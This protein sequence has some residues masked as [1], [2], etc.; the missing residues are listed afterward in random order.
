MFSL[1]WWRHRKAG[2][3]YP[4][5]AP[6]FTLYFSGVRVTRSLFYM[7]VLLIVVCPFVHFLFGHYVVCSFSICGFWLPLGI[8]KLFFKNCVWS[9]VCILYLLNSKIL[10][11]H[12]I[13]YIFLYVFPKRIFYFH[14]LLVHILRKECSGCKMMWYSLS[15]TFGRVLRFPPPL[16]LTATIELK[17]CWNWH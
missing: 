13:F 12:A 10:F 14:V 4:S 16:K 5:G 7:Y 3:V 9:I 11:K 8:F 1:L 17:Y 2:I 6:E 15:V